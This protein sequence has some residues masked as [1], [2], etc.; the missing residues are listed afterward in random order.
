M[1]DVSPVRHRSIIQQGHPSRPTAANSHN[2]TQSRRHI[3]L[4]KSI[5][6]PGNDAAGGKLLVHAISHA[7]TV[8]HHQT[9]VI[10]LRENQTTDGIGDIY[11]TEPA[12]DIHRRSKVAI[13]SGNAPLEPR[14]GRQAVGIVWRGKAVE[15]CVCAGNTG[16]RQRAGKRCLL[17]TSP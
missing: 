13:V 4:T 6:S 17:Y 12:A 10:Y 3:S 15:L 1:S 16:C 8:A 5:V 11:H 7:Q 9:T 2:V 14:S